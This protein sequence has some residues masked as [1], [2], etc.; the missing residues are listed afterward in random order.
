MHEVSVINLINTNNKKIIISP[1]KKKISGQKR[2]SKIND[3]LIYSIKYSQKIW[4]SLYRI[5]FFLCRQE[6]QDL[7]LSQQWRTREN[8]TCPQGY[9]IFLQLI[10]VRKATIDIYYTKELPIKKRTITITIQNI[11]HQF[12]KFT[13]IGLHA[14]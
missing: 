8:W 7:H 5:F 3:Y 12:T 9:I 6:G 11:Q 4:K 13:D 1:I 14:Q 10:M 2:A